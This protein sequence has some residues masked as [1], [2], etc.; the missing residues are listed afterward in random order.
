[1]ISRDSLGSQPELPVIDFPTP[2]DSDDSDSSDYN[3][4]EEKEVS[5]IDNY[6]DLH[7][8]LYD[9]GQFGTSGKCHGFIK[10]PRN[11]FIASS[12]LDDKKTS[13]KKCKL[14]RNYGWTADYKDKKEN[15]NAIHW[16]QV[17]LG[18]ITT[19]FAVAIQGKADA[20]EYITKGV[21]TVSN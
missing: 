19:I 15:A 6:L 1:M 3:H 18:K 12:V 2:S 16:I 4:N 13:A 20:D 17:D 5:W 21:L 9:V 14:N 8:L 7:K 11:H 10:L